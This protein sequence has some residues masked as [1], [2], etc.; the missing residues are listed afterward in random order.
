[1]VQVGDYGIKNVLEIIDLG[2]SVIS[3]LKGAQSDGKIDMNDVS[4]L[5]PAFM[6]LAPAIE[7]ITEVWNEVKDIEGSELD[8]IK[9][10]IITKWSAIPNINVKWIKFVE[11]AFKI[12]EGVI[13]GFEAYEEVTAE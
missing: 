5:I 9:N 11:A 12:A 8:E 13:L 7:D 4:Y 1:M 10:H 6:A 3:G 2:M